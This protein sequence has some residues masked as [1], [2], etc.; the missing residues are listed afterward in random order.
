MV[1]RMLIRRLCFSV[2]SALQK[3]LP[4][5]DGPGAVFEDRRGRTGT[6]KDR[7]QH[8][9]HLQ[10]TSEEEET[11]KGLLRGVPLEKSGQL[12]SSI[13]SPAVL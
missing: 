2:A 4:Q 6:G 7:D 1:R 12:R 13:G 5:H 3:V 11:E 10:N 8:A 9:H